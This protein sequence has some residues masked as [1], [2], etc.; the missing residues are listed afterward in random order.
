MENQIKT[1]NG[2]ETI[3]RNKGFMNIGFESDD[4]LPLGKILN[5]LDMI[6]VVRSVLQKDNKYYPIV[7][8]HE[9]VYESVDEL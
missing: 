1:I 6:I 2:G 4:V 5:I 3:E 7:C 8:L 9:C